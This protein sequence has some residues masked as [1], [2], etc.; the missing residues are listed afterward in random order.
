MVYKVDKGSGVNV[1]GSIKSTR[2]KPTS[3]GF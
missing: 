3:C 2:A 1:S